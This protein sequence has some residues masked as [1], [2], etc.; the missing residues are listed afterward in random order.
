MSDLSDPQIIAVRASE[1]KEWVS[2]IDVLHD[3]VWGAPEGEQSL[4]DDVTAN[5]SAGIVHTYLLCVHP[6]G[7]LLAMLIYRNPWLICQIEVLSATVD[8]RY[9]RRG[10]MKRLLRWLAQQYPGAYIWGLV[11]KNNEPALAIYRGLGATD[12][13]LKD[14]P[15]R[16][17]VGWEDV[18]I[19]AEATA[20]YQ[21]EALSGGSGDVD[22]N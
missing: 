11:R 14:D 17:H 10:L 7:E 4:T 1:A 18:T 13:E 20:W 8:P 12:A 3:V 22:P 15:D 21:E 2:R 5:D 16:I 9:R 19:Q 6:N